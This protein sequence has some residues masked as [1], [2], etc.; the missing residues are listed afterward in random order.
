[1]SDA[2]VKLPFGRSV[3][4]YINSLPILASGGLLKKL[5]RA[6][7]P[8]AE[9]EGLVRVKRVEDA[10]DYLAWATTAGKQKS[11]NRLDDI[12]ELTDA[13]REYVQDIKNGLRRVCIHT[14]FLLVF[15]VQTRF[16]S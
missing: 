8:E 16:I 2:Q 10:V 12:L 3:E 7:L 15:R 6:K 11:T 13:G 1:M 9:K 4:E 5:G 14:S